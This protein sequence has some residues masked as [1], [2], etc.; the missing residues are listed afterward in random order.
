VFSTCPTM[1]NCIDDERQDGRKRFGVSDGVSRPVAR[2]PGSD[3]KLHDVRILLAIPVRM[4]RRN[5]LF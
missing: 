5:L 3:S 2:A 1:M 4:E